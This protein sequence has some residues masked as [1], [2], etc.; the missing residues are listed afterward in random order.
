MQTTLSPTTQQRLS[1]AVASG[2]IQ[3]ADALVSDA[4]DALNGEG[5]TE[6]AAIERLRMELGPRFAEADAGLAVPFDV[7]SIKAEARAAA[8]IAG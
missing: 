4:L 1:D 8:G 3:S 5:L 2:R 6:A 7:E